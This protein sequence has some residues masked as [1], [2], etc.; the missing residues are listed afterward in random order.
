MC[1]H[2][3][4]DG[5]GQYYQT[6]PART[7]SCRPPEQNLARD[8]CRMASAGLFRFRMWADTT[9]NGRGHA[10]VCVWK[11]RRF[12]LSFLALNTPK[13]LNLKPQTR[14]KHLHTGSK[15]KTGIALPN[16]P[17]PESTIIMMMTIMV[18]TCADIPGQA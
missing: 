18:Q 7:L 1:A 3:V 11:P 12:C 2:Y 10:S 5:R 8:V 13:P 9:S 6:V 17:S 14:F 4:G 15:H 16:S